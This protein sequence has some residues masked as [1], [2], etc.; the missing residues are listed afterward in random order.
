MLE[1]HG[2]V[3]GTSHIGTDWLHCIGSSGSAPGKVQVP[4]TQ[5]F[6]GPLPWHAWTLA[7]MYQTR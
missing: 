2:I 4:S 6:Y 3:R 7:K 1:R 5:Y